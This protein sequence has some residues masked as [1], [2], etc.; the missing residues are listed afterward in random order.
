MQTLMQSAPDLA[1]LERDMGDAIRRQDWDLLRQALC[2]PLLTLNDLQHLSWGKLIGELFRQ[3]ENRSEITPGKK[4]EGLEHILN[5]VG[6]P[7][8]LFTRLESL[9]RSWSRGEAALDISLTGEADFAGEASASPTRPAPPVAQ[10]KAGDL[11]PGLREMLA[12]TLDECIAPLLA[13]HPDQAQE[14][15][16]LAQNIRQAVSLKQLGAVQGSLKR[17][18]FRLALVVEDQ[19]ELRASLLK[20]LRLVVENIGEL[21]QD[22]QWLH[23]QIE[24]I[25][26][27]VEKPLSQRTLDDAEQ[28]M[29]EVIF[30]QSQLK[31]SLQEAKNALKS[32]LSGFVD[33]LAD[34]ADATSDYHDTIEKYAGRISAANRI[35]DLG[36]VLEEVMRET[37]TIQTNAL[38]SRDELR[39]AQ[40]QA[41]EAQ[42][43]IQSLEK[44]LEET[45]HLIRHDQLTG[46]LNR[47]GLDEALQKEV[48]RAKR[49]ESPICVAL[50]D[51]DDFKKLNDSQGH[52]AGDEALIHLTCVI[53]EALRPQD[54]VAR[55]GGEE[56]IIVFPETDLSEASSAMIRL[57]RDL[58]R[59]FF[60]F[61]N[62][63]L[64]ITF[65]AGIAQL[66]EG[67]NEASIIQ[68][69]DAAMYQA[70]KSGKNRVMTEP[71]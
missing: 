9:G 24:I 16:T 15:R 10:S 59:R 4:R 48:A 55:Y 14:V 17:F 44:E 2:D 58:T 51:I 40:Q 62:Q 60:L 5:N 71:G 66:R 31:L 35:D 63:R 1:R 39:L 43:R 7:R 64:L 70:K 57:Q 3:W 11:L 32:L 8:T 38:R 18:T 50:L 37:R 69:A 36:N 68:R 6:N 49:R 12:H 33:H 13:D 25:R 22:D 65:S 53:R 56:F 45:S 19:A 67:E 34:F 26:E 52:V 61:Q 46:V 27:I 42:E 29:K 20:L 54:T 23:G 30:K 41:R 28:R 21:L 47:R